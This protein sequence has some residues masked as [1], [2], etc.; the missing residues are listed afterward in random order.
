MKPSAKQAS[1]DHTQRS[2]EQKGQITAAASPRSLDKTRIMTEMEHA[3]EEESNNSLGSIDLQNLSLRILLALSLKNK[4]LIT[5]TRATGA[6]SQDA[7]GEQLRNIGLGQNK[8]Q[9]N[10]FSGDELVILL[11]KTS[12]LIGGSE[13]QQECFFCELSALASLESP[14]KLAQDTPISFG[15]MILEYKEASHSISLSVPTCFVDELLQRH[16]LTEVEPTQSL[17]QEELR[18]QEASEHNFALNAD[19]RELYKQTVGDLVWLATCCRPDLSFEAHLLAQS[20]TSPTTSQ[21]MQ[22]QRV[23][24]YLAE[25]RHSSLSLHPATKITRDKPQSLELVAYSS[26]SWTEACKATSTAYLQ[27][28]GASLIASCKTACAQKQDHAELESVN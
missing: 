8:V 7:L 3:A 6:C 2:L 1:Q 12:I 22:L 16:D 4:W 13:L 27:L 15:N 20:L 14:N 11:D 9:P 21:Q 5:T 26:T 28:W 24:R 17:Q 10:I 25:T 23:L 19:Q 18:D